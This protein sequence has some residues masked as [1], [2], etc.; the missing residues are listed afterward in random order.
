LL[1]IRYQLYYQFQDSIILSISYLTKS[2]ATVSYV[3]NINFTSFTTNINTTLNSILN[4]N[5]TMNSD[6][7]GIKSTL[8]TLLSINNFNTTIAHY[9]RNTSISSYL[10]TN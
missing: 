4:N 2:D 7:N 6:I 9:F 5:T 3:S 8:P 10:L 1:I